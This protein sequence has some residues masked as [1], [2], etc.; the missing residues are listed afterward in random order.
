M[1]KCLIDNEICSIQKQRCKTCKFDSCKDLIKIIDE[2]ER[3][4]CR[5]NILKIIKELPEQC[6]KCSFLKII[7][8]ENKKVYC[9]YM[10]KKCVLKGNTK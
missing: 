9:P 3:I 1:E 2:T 8:T 10:I 5:R 4:K 7:S 6:K